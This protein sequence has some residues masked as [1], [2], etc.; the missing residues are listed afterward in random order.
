MWWIDFLKSLD[1]IVDAAITEKVDLVIFAGDAYKDRSPA[2]T[3]QREWGKRIIR[4]SKAG[5]RTLLLVGN[6]DLSPA[7][8]RAN[9]IH[10]APDAGPRS[11]ASMPRSPVALATASGPV[12]RASGFF[13]PRSPTS[14]AMISAKTGVVSGGLHGVGVSVTN[15][16]SE[17]CE[18]EV[19]RDGKPPP[20]D[21]S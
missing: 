17:W 9:A 16:L 7:I 1:T 8:G 3:F 2:P 14:R 4:L 21:A 15:A 6:H 13:P 10:Q 12:A 19:R 20:E 18:V 11:S 5:I